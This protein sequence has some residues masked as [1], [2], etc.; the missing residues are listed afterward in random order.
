VR[1]NPRFFG[2]RGVNH[3]RTGDY[4]TQREVQILKELN[5]TK[6]PEEKGKRSNHQEDSTWITRYS[7]LILASQKKRL[8]DKR[9][10][11]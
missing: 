2:G 3:I 5:R 1:K 9:K 6:S 11:S 4:E 10:G 7:E 8:G